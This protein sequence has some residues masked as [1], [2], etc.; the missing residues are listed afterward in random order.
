MEI[1]SL[2]LS[3][4]QPITKPTNHQITKS[5]N[6]TE[7]EFGDMLK[8]AASRVNQDILT[9]HK[10]SESMAAGEQVDIARTMIDI[11]KA[12][13]SFKMLLQVRNKAL[14]AYEE[15]MRLQF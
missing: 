11:T 12:D 6:S 7:T 9:A 10:R 5:P 13:V 15:V 2:T 1:D 14:S 3:P 4:N 8:N